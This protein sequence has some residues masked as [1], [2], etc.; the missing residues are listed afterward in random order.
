MESVCPCCHNR[1]EMIDQS[2]ISQFGEFVIS[3][4]CPVCSCSVKEIEHLGN[5]YWRDPRPKE[6]QKSCDHLHGILDSG[7]NVYEST[8]K[9]SRIELTEGFDDIYNFC[10]ECGMMLKEPQT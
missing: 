5:M 3:L 2:G 10:P 8:L 6:A 1:V 7:L 9:D 4:L